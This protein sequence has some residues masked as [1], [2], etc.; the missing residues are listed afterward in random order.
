MLAHF[1]CCSL[2]Y[3]LY[4]FFC[5]LCF[6]ATIKVLDENDTPPRFSQSFYT[7][8]IPE[9][10]D[11]AS[12]VATVAVADDDTTGTLQLTISEGSE[13]NF[14]IHQDGELNPIR[15]FF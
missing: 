12:T 6:Q 2:L 1:A 15:I 5:S 10:V 11:L 13:G 7:E 9:D 3:I 14:R 4:N 8:S